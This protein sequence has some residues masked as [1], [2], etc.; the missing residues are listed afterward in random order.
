MNIDRVF[1]VYN[2]HDCHHI[3]RHYMTYSQENI[4]NNIIQ[5]K[6]IWEHQFGEYIVLNECDELKFR[7]TNIYQSIN[8]RLTTECLSNSVLIKDEHSQCNQTQ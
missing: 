6:C 5:R 8:T 7:S 2:F 3:I 4:F 1:C